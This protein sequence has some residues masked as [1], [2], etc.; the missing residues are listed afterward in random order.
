M[1]R[2]WLVDFKRRGSKRR[3]TSREFHVMLSDGKVIYNG[4]DEKDWNQFGWL[5]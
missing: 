3:K 1:L 4:K 2:F 5:N